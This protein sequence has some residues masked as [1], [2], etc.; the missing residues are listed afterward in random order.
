MCCSQA[1]WIK[2][3]KFEREKVSAGDRFSSH[4][5]HPRV[6]VTSTSHYLLRCSFDWAW[7]GHLAV[8]LCLISSPWLQVCKKPDG[9][10]RNDFF[11]FKCVLT[12]SGMSHQLV[13]NV[14]YFFDSLLTHAPKFRMSLAMCWSSSAT[15]EQADPETALSD[16]LDVE[17]EEAL[18]ELRGFFCILCNHKTGRMFD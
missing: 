6:T 17:A 13:S 12:Y 7:G 16:L 8:L 4:V 11:F 14:L 5:S 15:P 3:T 18:T 10:V 1:W 2:L 9:F